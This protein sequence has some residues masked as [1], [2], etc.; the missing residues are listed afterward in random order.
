MVF[1]N[2]VRLMVIV[3]YTALKFAIYNISIILLLLQHT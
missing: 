1:T 3:I 2:V